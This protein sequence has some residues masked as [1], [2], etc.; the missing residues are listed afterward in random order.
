MDKMRWPQQHR[1]RSVPSYRSICA[2]AAPASMQRI[3][4]MRWLRQMQQLKVK[5][6]RFKLWLQKR[7]VRVV[8]VQWWRRSRAGGRK[9]DPPV[10]SRAVERFRTSSRE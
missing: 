5:V 8:L 1:E 6:R 3:A 4:L 2:V 7:E 9:L 10:P